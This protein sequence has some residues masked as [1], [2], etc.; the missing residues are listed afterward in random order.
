MPL[1]EEQWE[2]QRELL[3]IDTMLFINGNVGFDDFSGR[4]EIRPQELLSVDAVYHRFVERVLLRLNGNGT[5]AVRSLKDCLGEMRREGG[6]PVLVE[7]S[8]GDALARLK[9]GRDWRIHLNAARAEA[10]SRC[11]GERNLRLRFRAALELDDE[12]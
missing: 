5:A 6:C 11:V 2:A 3:K 8:N 1:N 4:H 12:L 10:L 9:L 7:Y